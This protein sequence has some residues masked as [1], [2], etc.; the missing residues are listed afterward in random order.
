[1]SDDEDILHIKKQKTIHYG[2]LE[3][4][5]RALL[6]AVAV[7]SGDSDEEGSSSNMGQQIAEAG[8]VNISDGKYECCLQL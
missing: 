3:E 8:N 2:S 6:S 4:Q 5:E 1:M 7:K